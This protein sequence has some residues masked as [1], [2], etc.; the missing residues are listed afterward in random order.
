MNDETPRP[1]PPHAAGRH[2]PHGDRQNLAGARRKESQAMNMWCCSAI[3]SSTT[4]PMSAAGP[5][6]SRSS[7]RDPA[8]GLDRDARR[9]RRLDQRRHRRPAQGHA[10][11]RDPSRGVGRRQQR[12]AREGADRGEGAVGR[13]GA[14]QARQDQGRLPQ[15]LCGHARRRAGAKL[16]TAICTIY[17]AHY[18]DPTTRGDRCDWLERVQRRDLREAFARALPVI[19]LRLI[20]ND[21]A[22]YANDIE[23]SVE[24]GAKIAQ[25]RSPRWSP[26]H[27]FK[28]RRSVVYV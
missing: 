26:P 19:D 1:D 28:Q 15:E 25:E 23:P 10:G 13:R 22:D 18:P 11:E 9:A 17:E 12:A 14:R 27:D 3:R 2:G 6:S 5:T 21:D 7:R 8:R 20:I 24:G 16:P 4:S